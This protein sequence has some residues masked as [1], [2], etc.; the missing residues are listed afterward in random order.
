MQEQVKNASSSSYAIHRA[1]GDVLQHFIRSG[2]AA[3]VP[4]VASPEN[5]LI[6]TDVDPV[7][8]PGRIEQPDT[9]G[10]SAG[11]HAV[12]ILGNS[13]DGGRIRAGVLIPRATGPTRIAVDRAMIA[14]V[15]H[16]RV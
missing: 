6:V 10:E 5:A 7:R 4:Q 1:D 14:P 11:D 9:A 2:R 8:V 16:P 3:S 15:L 13:L 12:Q